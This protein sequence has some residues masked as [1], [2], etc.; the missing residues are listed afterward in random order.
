MKKRGKQLLVACAVPVLILI[1]MC[2]TPVYTLLTGEEI[3]LETIPVD[4]SDLFRGDYV[5]LRYEAEEIPKQLVEDAVINEVEKRWGDTE[6]YVL[7]RKNNAVHTPTKVTLKKP[8]KGIFLKGKVNYIGSEM[9]GKQVA[10]IQYSL[11]KYY[12]EDNT[13]TE[14]ENASS[15]GQLL[16]KARVKNGYAV[17]TD[18]VKK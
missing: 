8:D 17:L 2:F 3:I 18:I 11:D 14:W 5:T 1:G 10:Y 7:L 12:V 16:A 9:N 4:P 15:Q 13:G 6:V